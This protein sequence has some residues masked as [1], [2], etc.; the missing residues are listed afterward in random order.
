[1][2]NIILTSEI[3]PGPATEH[4]K[5]GGSLRHKAM[6]Q[7]SF[8]WKL[9]LCGSFNLRLYGQSFVKWFTVSIVWVWKGKLLSTSMIASDWFNGKPEWNG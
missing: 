7:E 2:K 8:V 4:Y 9:N 6:T 3:I 1:M 5:E